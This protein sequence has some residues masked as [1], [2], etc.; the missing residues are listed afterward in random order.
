MVCSQTDR[1]QHHSPLACSP[2]RASSYPSSYA[3]EAVR[4]L[5][6]AVQRCPEVVLA[7]A[8]AAVVVVEE[9]VVVVA[10]QEAE[11]AA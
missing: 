7:A 2:A 3:Q 9:D 5:P 4:A 10:P 11:A 6:L 1:L 8:V